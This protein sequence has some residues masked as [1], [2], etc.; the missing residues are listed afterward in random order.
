MEE[1]ELRK[2]LTTKN[3]CRIPK[4][5]PIPDTSFMET[6]PFRPIPPYRRE[7]VIFI[8]VLLA[9]C[10]PGVILMPK[11]SIGIFYYLNNDLGIIIFRIVSLKSF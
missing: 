10:G 7:K 2:L 9:C 1:S 4:M 8:H 3:G 5:L 11:N 6:L